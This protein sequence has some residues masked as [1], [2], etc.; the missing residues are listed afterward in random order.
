MFQP[1]IKYDISLEDL[2]FGFNDY[3]RAGNQAV[4]DPLNDW[5]V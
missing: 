5:V 1:E 3:K 4:V 2:K